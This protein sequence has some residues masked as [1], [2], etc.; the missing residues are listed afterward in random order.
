MRW[1]KLAKQSADCPV[2]SR[3]GKY[4][5]FQGYLRNESLICGVRLS[6]R[7]LEI[8]ANLRS[9]RRLAFGSLF[10]WFGLTTYGS[11][12]VVRDVGGQEIYALDWEAP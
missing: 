9:L 1:A 6:D 5:Y 8:A 3:D 2:W 7:K 4:V 12:L 10:L 11:F